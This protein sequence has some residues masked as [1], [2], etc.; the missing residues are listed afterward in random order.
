MEPTGVE[1]TGMIGR[2]EA[3]GATE[4]MIS[5]GKV[6]S[7]E[8]ARAADV[9][10]ASAELVI[11]GDPVIEDPRIARDEGTVVEQHRMVGPVEAPVV[12]SPAKAGEE[13]DPDTEAESDAWSRE[14]ES[15]VRVPARQRHQR[16]TIGEPGIILRDI[17]DVRVGRLNDDLLALRGYRLLRRASQVPRLLRTLA[18]IL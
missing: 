12:P 15:R 13:A 18:Q 5:T 1:P 4:V 9:M 10:E 11:D 6:G 16:R 17:N 14:I 8:M 3:L 7:A 2:S